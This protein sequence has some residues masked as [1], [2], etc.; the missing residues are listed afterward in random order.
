MSQQPGIPAID[1]RAAH[2]QAT[3]PEAPA[4]LLDVREPN[5]FE[6][7]RAEGAVLLPMSSFVVRMNE[8]P[9][10]R[11]ILVICASG[12]RSAAVAGH[13]LRN[14]WTEVVNVAGGTNGWEKAGLPTR[15]GTPDPG[16]GDLP[17][18]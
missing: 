2:E 10:D 13:L 7:V 3:A 14:G 12:N 17:G 4:L 16:E 11:P 6:A 15:R 18:G 9:K 8:L 5:E 1:V